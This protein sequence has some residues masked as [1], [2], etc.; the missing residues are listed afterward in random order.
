MTQR[1]M[2]IKHVS[3]LIELL[4]MADDDFLRWLG[5]ENGELENLM[6]VFEMCCEHYEDVVGHVHHAEAEAL[7]QGVEEPSWPVEETR[8]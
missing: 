7:L 2:K 5:L 8:H 3:A 1:V 4:S 6:E